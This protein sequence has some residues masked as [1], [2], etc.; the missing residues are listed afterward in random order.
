MANKFQA[1][2]M[3]KCLSSPIRIVKWL[4]EGGQG[5]VYVVEQNGEKKALK[6]YK[7]KI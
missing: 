6:W 4:A 1:G 2:D 3:I 7:P 5:D